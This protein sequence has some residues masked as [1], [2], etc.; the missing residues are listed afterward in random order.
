MS[1]PEYYT[2][3][4]LAKIL[5]HSPRQIRRWL[6]AGEWPCVQLGRK[7]M[8]PRKDFDDWKEALD[9]DARGRHKQRKRG[10]LQ[11]ARF[12]KRA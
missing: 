8:V 9:D 3:E 5:R 7:R 12:H 11:N 4:D 1:N 6:D 10:V 2:V